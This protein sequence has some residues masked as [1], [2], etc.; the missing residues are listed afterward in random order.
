MKITIQK[1]TKDMLPGLTEVW[2]ACFND[3]AAYIAF[4][5]ACNFLR[6]ET[7]AALDEERAVGMLH[8]IPASIDGRLAYYGYAMA[9]CP[10]TGD[11]N[12]SRA[13]QNGFQPYA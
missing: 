5:Y 9:C 13:A 8:L 4:F 3:D 12:F 1:A 6:I 10:N 2:R 11:G 7:Y